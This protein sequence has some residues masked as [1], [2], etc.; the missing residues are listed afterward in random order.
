MTGLELGFDKNTKHLVLNKTRKPN[1]YWTEEN[2]IKELTKVIE[3]LGHFPTYPE[4]HELNRN[5]LRGAIGK[6]DGINYFRGLLKFKINHKSPGYWT[7]ENT[8]IELG[9]VI[10]KLGYFPTSL[11]LH[12]L[13]RNDLRDAM[14]KHGG[15][16]HFKKLL[17]YEINHKSPGY[18]TEENTFL[19]LKL[20]IKFLGHFPLNSEL[21]NMKRSDLS[22]AMMLNGG[23][24]KFREV[25]GYEINTK[26]RGYWTDKAVI[27]ELKTIIKK[28]NHFPTQTDLE[29]FKNYSL[30]NGIN[31]SG[32]YIK[33]RNL[34]GYEASYKPD[35]YWNKKNTF[36]EL[37]LVMKDI[38]H[39]PTQKE[40]SEMKRYDLITG[41]KKHG[42]LNKLRKEFGYE[43]LHKPNGYW[44]EK[45]TIIHL[46]GIIEK[47]GYFPSHS[48][49]RE[50]NESGLSTSISKNGGFPKF[51]EVLGYPISMQEKYRSEVSLYVGKR[52]KASELIVKKILQDW[53]EARNL[54]EMLCN[55]K[56]SPGNIIEFV[57][58]TNR[59]IGI[60]VTNTDSRSNVIRKWKHKDY[61]KNLDDLWIIVFSNK[62]AEKDYIKLNEE[63]PENVT[64]MSIDDFL[65][66]LDYSTNDYLRAKIDKY[67]GCTFRS[68]SAYLN[69][70]INKYM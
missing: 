64:I 21:R 50:M 52:G 47:L 59:S 60:D 30:I 25:L 12:K 23:F 34:L 68:K 41:I 3:V 61:H 62:F 48:D 69:N 29:R 11:E 63:C 9:S 54:P 67:K 19:E 6:G 57:C 49:L 22:S 53:L 35:K 44:N 2:I 33:F 10:E 26:S 14:K 13:N 37:K 24:N 58:N 66:N 15:I 4:L 17:G 38:K 51:R 20:I 28:L 56:L 8:L 31:R 70:S 27:D 42:G 65:G 36:F 45:T 39:F 16:N 40:L 43:P 1:G 55:V 32:G 18:W 46:K 5:D 7:E